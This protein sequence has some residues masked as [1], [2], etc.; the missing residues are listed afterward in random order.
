V[1]ALYDRDDVFYMHGYTKAMANRILSR[2]AVRPFAPKFCTQ[3]S[4]PN[5]SRQ[6]TRKAF[7]VFECQLLRTL[8]NPIKVT[9]RL[10]RESLTLLF[11]DRRG[12]LRIPHG[13]VSS[14]LIPDCHPFSKARPSL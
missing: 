10:K 1:L 9:S 13:Y 6:W 4:H 11:K 7:E 14:D 2:R 8:L 12:M 5:R 3:I